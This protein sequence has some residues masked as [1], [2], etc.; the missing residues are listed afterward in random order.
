[1]A[2][3]DIGAVAADRST[4]ISAENT[5]FGLDNPANAGGTIDTIEVWFA[6][7]ATGF[8]VGTFFLVSGTTYECRDSETIGSVTSGSKQTFTELSIDVLIDDCIG[9]YWSGGFLEA[10]GTGYAGRYSVSG[11]HIDP[12]DQATYSLY[13]GD[14]ISLYG[15]GELAPSGLENKSANMAAKMVAAG[16]I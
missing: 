14:A 2:G 7:D 1:M 3:I 13:E 6:I 8:R 12:S 16:V 10:D 15:E 9:S 5:T 4:A 11:E